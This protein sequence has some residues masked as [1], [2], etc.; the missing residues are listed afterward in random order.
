MVDHDTSIV[1][2]PALIRKILIH[3]VHFD[4]RFLCYDEAGKMR[5][6]RLFLNGLVDRDRVNIECRNQAI[7]GCEWVLLRAPKD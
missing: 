4:P 1:I 2:G 7:K 6:P 5:Y 3:S